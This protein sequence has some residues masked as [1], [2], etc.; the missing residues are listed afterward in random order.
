MNPYFVEWK[1]NPEN[2]FEYSFSENYEGICLNFEMGTIE[3]CLG[4]IEYETAEILLQKLHLHVERIFQSTQILSHSPYNFRCRMIFQKNPDGTRKIPVSVSIGTANSGESSTSLFS[5]ESNISIERD[6]QTIWCPKE[7][8]IK[9]K[10]ENLILM[11]KHARDPILQRLLRS[12]HQAVNDSENEFIYLYEIYDA[13]LAKFKKE[14]MPKILGLSKEDHCDKFVELTNNKAYS[15][16]RHRGQ[17]PIDKIESA[18][19]SQLNQAREIA[20]TLIISY[21]KYLDKISN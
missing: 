14:R 5:I 13:L 9:L 19:Q 3:G 4:C 11:E 17:L 10:Q 7:K 15:Q 12:Y 21:L 1:F 2:F 8:R 6:G 16:G 18:P 20:Q